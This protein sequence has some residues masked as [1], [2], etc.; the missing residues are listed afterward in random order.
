MTRSTADMA[1]S[2]FWRTTIRPGLSH[3]LAGT[4]DRLAKQLAVHLA[5]LLAEPRTN[6]PW[7][8]AAEAAVYLRCPTSRIRKLTSTRE[9]PFH[10]DGRRVLYHRDELDEFVR[11]GGATCP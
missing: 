5:P 4:P 6:S 8:N 1:A 2:V 9:L 7:L 11:A 3:D 10:R